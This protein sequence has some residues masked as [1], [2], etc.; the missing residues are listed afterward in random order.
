MRY[1]RSMSEDLFAAVDGMA[2]GGDPAR[3]LDLLAAKFIEARNYP[4]LFETRLMKKRFESGLPL[5]QTESA[6]AFPEPARRDYEQAMVEAARETGSLFLDSGNIARAWPYFRAIGEPDPVRKAI[7]GLTPSAAEEVIDPVIPIAFQ[8]GVHPVKGLELILGRYGMCRAITSFGMYP[9]SEGREECIHLLVSSLY[10]ELAGNLARAIEAHEGR[11]PSTGT[12]GGLIAGRDWLFGEYDYYVDTSHLASVLQY[13][14]GVTRRDTLLLAKELCDY[15][16][17]LSR[18][19]QFAGQAPFEDP[20]IDYGM[21]VQALLGED[22][23]AALAHFRDK[24]LTSRPEDVGPYPAETLVRLL[25][26]LKHFEEAVDISLRCLA[27]YPESNCPN[28]LHLCH[29]AGDYAR[30][31][32]LARERGDVLSYFAAVAAE[33]KVE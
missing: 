5:I 3:I 11:A 21:Y 17:R 6:A 9:V 18:Q 22:A 12:V 1:D 33:A 24:V 29:M 16:R 2:Q 25:V 4:L 32:E 14:P 13:L 26:R 7:D 31:R 19:F 20:F 27:G 15:G 30:L 10:S 8:E 23:E 28:A